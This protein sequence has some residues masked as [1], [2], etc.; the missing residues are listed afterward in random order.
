[1]KS[2]TT[3]GNIPETLLFN[4]EN[5]Q[6][7]LNRYSTVFFKP[8]GGSGGAYIVRIK[9]ENGVYKVKYKNKLRTMNSFD[10]IYAWMKS[11]AGD[12]SY[13]LQRGI[14]LARTNGK[15]FDIRVMLQKNKKGIWI[16]S[17]IFAKV[18][19]PGKV[20]TN[21]N[22]GGKLKYIEPTLTGAG[23]SKKQVQ[24]QKQ[25]LTTVGRAVAKVFDQHMKGFK[26]LGLDVAIENNRKLWILEVN[27]RPQFYPLKKMPNKKFYQRILNA[28]KQYGRKK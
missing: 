19:L 13:I 8:T 17:A 22:Q 25:E 21:Y 26:E 14:S 5:L 23:F 18:G 20:A 3:K 10:E 16:T 15:P 6:A 1:M 24:K 7:M 2:D 4:K 28:S 9:V 12:R 27:T 11:F